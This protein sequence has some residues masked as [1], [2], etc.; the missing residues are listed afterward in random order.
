MEGCFAEDGLAE[1]GLV[2]DGLAG[3]NPAESGLA[4]ALPGTRAGL[5][6]SSAFKLRVLAGSYRHPPGNHA[7]LEGSSHCGNLSPG[8]LGR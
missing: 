7:A 3:D 1:D 8:P 2:G 5:A 6:D 4:E